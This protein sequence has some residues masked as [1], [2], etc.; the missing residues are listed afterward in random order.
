MK[1]ILLFILTSCLSLSAQPT[2][3]NHTELG[4]PIT[5]KYFPVIKEFPKR[6]DGLDMYVVGYDT[7]LNSSRW[8]AWHLSSEWYGDAERYSGNFITDNEVPNPIKHT[9]ITNS[10]YERGHLVR[11][12]ERTMNDAQN[13][14]TFYMTN[15]LP[16]TSNLN[17]R[18]WY[19]LE[20]YCEKLCKE[21]NKDL[22]IIAGG[23]F[24]SGKKIN[25]KVPVP[26]TCWKIVVIMEKGQKRKDVNEN[27]EIIAVKMPN[28]DS[29]S[30]KYYD[31]LCTVDDIENSTDFDFFSPLDMV[32]QNKIEAKKYD[33]LS[34]VEFEEPVKKNEE[35]I[36]VDI[37]GRPWVGSYEY[38]ILKGNVRIVIK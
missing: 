14:S 5:F 24:S 37:L 13:K 12:E 38:S 23:I 35:E 32:L 16:Q 15:V 17:Q 6:A 28:I 25:D 8:V 22:Y 3:F 30:G 1:K 11:S 27:T 34:S 21:R 9:D 26:D 31:Y 7:V 2:N 18:V 10:G 33:Y 4:V 36:I 19:S 29:V 20:L